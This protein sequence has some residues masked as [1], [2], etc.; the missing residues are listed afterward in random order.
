MTLIYARIFNLSLHENCW[1][2]KVYVSWNYFKSKDFFVY[3]EIDHVFKIVK[4]SFLNRHAI[5][6]TQQAW[7]WLFREFYGLM[8]IKKH[9]SSENLSFRRLYQLPRFPFFYK[10]NRTKQ[11]LFSCWLRNHLVLLTIPPMYQTRRGYQIR[12][13]ITTWG[14]GEALGKC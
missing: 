6:V 1:N 2:F 8:I 3:Y 9:F 11:K 7:T 5:L 4:L 14:R 10:E 13:H 12:I